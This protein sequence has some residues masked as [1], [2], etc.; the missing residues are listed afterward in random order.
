MF[1]LKP[2][3]KNLEEMLRLPKVS[4]YDYLLTTDKDLVEDD[5]INIVFKEAQTHKINRLLDLIVNG[6]E[7]FLVG[8]NERGQK[9]VEVRSIQYVET[10]G[11]D[12]Y[13]VMK[14]YRLLTKNKLY[15]LE[16][17]LND[18]DFIRVSKS[19][20]V[21]IGKI[22]YIKPAINSRIELIM[23]NDDIVEVKRTYLKDFKETL[24]I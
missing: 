20:L 2:S 17:E 9:R 23:N 10:F 15:Q 21:N 5:K 22:R 11:D 3:N 6:E 24:K 14:D 18:I 19:H 4:N 16:K 12:V 13:L 7:V 1:K 8:H